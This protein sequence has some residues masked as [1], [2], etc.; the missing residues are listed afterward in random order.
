VFE[1][2]ILLYRRLWR[3]TAFSFFVVPTLYLLSMGLGVGGYVGRVAGFGYLD[4]ITPG[5]LATLAFQVGV[6]E[7]TYG[8][9]VEFAWVGGMHVMRN[10]R[11]SIR[12][13]LA[14]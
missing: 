1:R 7:S 4:W 14:G 9:F 5:L 11:V 2:H 6:S 12:D 13:M 10:T 8:V 3:T